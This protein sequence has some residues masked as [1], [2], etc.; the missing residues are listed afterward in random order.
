MICGKRISPA[1]FSLSVN[2]GIREALAE[3]A[4]QSDKVPSKYASIVIPQ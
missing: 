1:A 4:I 3:A 2:A